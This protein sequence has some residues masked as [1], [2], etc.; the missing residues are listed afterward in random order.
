MVRRS[1]VVLLLISCALMLVMPSV[2]SAQEDIGCSP[3]ERLAGLQGILGVNRGNIVIVGDVGVAAF[4][5]IEVDGDFV[6]VLA[7]ATNQ[8]RRSSNIFGRVALRDDQ[9]RIYDALSS[10]DF[11]AYGS[12]V[13]QLRS[14]PVI[15]DLGVDVVSQSSNLQPGRHAFIPLIFQVAPDSAGLHLVS[16]R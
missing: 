13:R 1:L 5:T 4:C 11:P 7:I 2:A 16:A 12:V 8:G 10:L 15:A 3:S 6:A 9:G 14:M